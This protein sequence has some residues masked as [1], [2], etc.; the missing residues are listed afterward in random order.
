MLYEYLCDSCGLGIESLS[1][2]K[3]GQVLDDC[4]ESDCDGELVRCV[5]LFNVTPVIQPY[6]NH[7]VGDYVTST[8]DFEE[9]LRVG[10]EKQTERTGTQH[11]YTPVYP[12][13]SKAHQ[14]KVA[15]NDGQNGQ[16]MDRYGNVYNLTNKKRKIFH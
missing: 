3:I 9:K 10:A 5:S 14:E 6:F 4:P 12:S 1:F 8:R 2:R 15:N 11:T 7:T 16:S 13:E